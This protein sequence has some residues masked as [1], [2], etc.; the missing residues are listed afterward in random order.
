MNSG[1][2]FH[3]ISFSSIYVA[4]FSMS[5][6]MS[7]IILN[8]LVTGKVVLNLLGHGG[9]P[10]RETFNKQDDLVSLNEKKILSQGRIKHSSSPR[11][12]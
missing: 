3:P 7:S 10:H 12:T 2:M 4:T 11:K 9:S 1:F 5:T 8:A 6:P